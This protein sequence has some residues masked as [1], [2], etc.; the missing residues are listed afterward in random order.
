M[1]RS[2]VTSGA[3]PFDFAYA[4]INRSKGSRVQPSNSAVWITNENECSQS[5]SAI[6]SCN[7]LNSACGGC[8]IFLISYRYSSSSKTIGEMSR[9]ASSIA[10]VEEADQLISPIV[11]LELE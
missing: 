11:L 2:D 6:C 1:S 10:A 9:S 4:T 3:Y 5:L 7:W 8:M